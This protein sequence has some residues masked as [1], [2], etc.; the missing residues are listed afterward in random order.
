MTNYNERYTKAY[1]SYKAVF[2]DLENWYIYNKF[3]K[4][5]LISEYLDTNEVKA[6]HDNK[7]LAGVKHL[8]EVVK[9]SFNDLVKPTQYK[10]VLLNKL[11]ECSKLDFNN[12]ALLGYNLFT[13]EGMVK[14][15]SL[16]IQQYDS[17]IAKFNQV[18]KAIPNT[19][20][21]E[22]KVQYTILTKALKSTAEIISDEKSVNY[23]QNCE[24]LET[25]QTVREALA[26]VADIPK[27]D[28][29]QSLVME[30]N[31]CASYKK[32][33][34]AALVQKN[35]LVVV[36]QCANLEFNTPSDVFFV[37][38]RCKA[39]V[40]TYLNQ[41]IKINQLSADFIKTYEG[42]SNKSQSDYSGADN[43]LTGISDMS[44]S[45]I[46]FSGATMPEISTKVFFSE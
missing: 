35:E 14:G 36:E 17:S 13:C 23:N 3:S 12:K 22:M 34:E 9:E 11:E 5:V 24:L 8:Y 20:I 37:L 7:Y 38:N 26:F 29:G 1:T 2:E 39:M 31:Q 18:A 44:P 41:Y 32:I 43:F 45:G 21:D 6:L 27:Q 10:Q 15:S 42:D 33:Y 30:L 19:G 25:I 28:I 46:V 40:Y 4:I 16:V